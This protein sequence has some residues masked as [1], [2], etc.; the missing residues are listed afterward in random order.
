MRFKFEV[1][2]KKCSLRRK[3]GELGECVGSDGGA[4]RLKIRRPCGEHFY[5]IIDD[6]NIAIA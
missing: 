6:E 4:M 1:L 2:D 5:V 3:R